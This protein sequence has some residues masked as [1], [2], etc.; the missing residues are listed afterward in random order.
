M[1]LNTWAVRWNGHQVEVRNH[2]FVAE[3]LVDGELVDRVPGVI[4]HDLC[5]VLD[6]G[7]VRLNTRPCPDGSC[8]Y[9]NRPAARFCAEC[10][11]KLDAR[12]PGHEVRA[13]V[14]VHFPPPG[15][16]CRI[17]VDGEEILRE[18]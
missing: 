12:W 16:R 2:F 17:L 4:R 6:D 10:G 14:E 18:D 15:I 5:A 3:L 7:E 9:R 1:I 11:Q 13:T 8:G